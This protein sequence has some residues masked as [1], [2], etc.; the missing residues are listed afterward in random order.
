MTAW[1]HLTSFLAQSLTQKSKPDEERAI[2]GVIRVYRGCWF[3]LLYYAPYRPLPRPRRSP[4]LPPPAALSDVP[5]TA[6][7][8]LFL[9]HTMDS[10]PTDKVEGV[11][12]DFVRGGQDKTPIKQ[13]RNSCQRIVV[14][15]S[16]LPS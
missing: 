9:L 1:S 7:F 4:P 15:A 14:S 3:V 16:T 13:K 10:Q 2:R 8:F 11:G 6:A 12:D 5:Y